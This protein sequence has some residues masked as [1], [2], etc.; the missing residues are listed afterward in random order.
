[1]SDLVIPDEVIEAA[2]KALHDRDQLAHEEWD[3]CPEEHRDWVCK[4]AYA[5]L[6]AALEEWGAKY[7]LRVQPP[8]EVDPFDSVERALGLKPDEIPQKPDV[9]Y[10][11]HLVTSWEPHRALSEST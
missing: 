11:R 9:Q 5:A 7:W 3:A 2:A 10:E 4:E 8:P 1:M 6:T